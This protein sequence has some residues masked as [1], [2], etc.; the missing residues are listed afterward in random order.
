MIVEPKYFRHRYSPLAL[1]LLPVSLCYLAGDF[2]NRLF[3]TPYRSRA[4]VI[5][6]GNL[7]VGGVGKTPIVIKV[8]EHFARRGTRV[9]VMSRGYGGRL[10]GMHPVVVDPRKHTA[11]DV[12]DEPYMIASKLRGVP[13]C[14]CS[15]R[16][17]SARLLE[18]FVDVIV[19][20][21]GLQNYSIAK[22]VKVSVFDGRAGL[23][24]G[25]V[26]PAGPLRQLTRTCL[27]DVDACVIMSE[28]NASL[29]HKLSEY[30]K[31]IFDARA[32]AKFDFMKLRGK[33]AVAFAGIGRP[34]KFLKTLEEN[35]VDV[36]RWHAF[37][38]HHE[39]RTRELDALLREA[40]RLGAVL[41][42]TMK[43]FVKIPKSYQKRFTP[44]DIDV[45]I[46]NSGRFMRLLGK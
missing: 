8:V 42:T 15:D 21:D 25:Y 14:I 2:L 24:N 29:E 10:S 41:L 33:K 22:D 32:V 20:D 44:V 6:I 13:V 16:A 35:K 18:E 19:M 28:K 39:Y 12:G 31:N 43:D 17:R 37:A 7:T 45:A 26:L 23:G 30:T 36:I 4:R 46:G 40:G 1:A 5:C 11:L 34:H 38:D 9:G 27:S 3:S